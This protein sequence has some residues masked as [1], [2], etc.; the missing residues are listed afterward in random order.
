MRL[1]RV[2]ILRRAFMLID[3]RDIIAAVK[4]MFRYSSVFLYNHLYKPSVFQILFLKSGIICDKSYRNVNLSGR[5]GE[6]EILKRAD[7]WDL[8]A[9]GTGQ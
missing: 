9:S 4:K 1:L 2:Q 8:K 3:G 5:K 7:G 6:F